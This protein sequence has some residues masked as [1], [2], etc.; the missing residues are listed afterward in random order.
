MKRENEKKLIKKYPEFFEYL[1]DYKGPIMPMS[2]GFECGDGWYFILDNLLE[3]CQ[4]KI[5]HSKKWPERK[6]KSQFW[7]YIIKKIEKRLK[8]KSQKWNKIWKLFIKFKKNF[9]FI[10]NKPL[11]IQVL[12]VKEKYGGLRFYFNSSGGRSGEQDEIEGMV[13]LAESMSYGTCEFCG[14]T[15][16]VGQTQG[17]ITT[18][19]EKCF[20]EKTN[21]AKW[22]PLKK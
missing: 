6:I 5:K 1:K 19:C 20:K 9:K 22:K 10:E 2:F 12:Q 16:N 13:N 17:W 7:R 21:M 8:F 4:D 15:K 18:C 3:Q 11:S 14:T